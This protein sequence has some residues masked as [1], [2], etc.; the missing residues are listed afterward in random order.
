[1]QEKR[2]SFS[3]DLM[4]DRE[5]RCDLE[6]AVLI[7]PRTVFLVEPLGVFEVP[8]AQKLEQGLHLDAVSV[9]S[10]INESANLFEQMLV[11]GAVFCQTGK[12]M[13]LQ[14]LFFTVK[15]AAGE[16]NQEIELLIDGFTG[17]A[18]H[19]H[20]PKF[21]HRIHQ[22]AVLI[23]HCFYA[24]D[25][26]VTPRQKGHLSIHLSLSTLSL[27]RGMTIPLRWKQS[28]WAKCC[29]STHARTAWGTH[30]RITSG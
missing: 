4:G 15:V 13:L 6:H 1:M 18:S 27:W 19:Q 10:M 14:Q 21:V 3:L 2:G 11:G 17:T 12:T 8:D 9:F 23:V 20:M 24:D 29:E 28:V 7:E 26:V 30:S 25:A 16:F 22:Y 5:R